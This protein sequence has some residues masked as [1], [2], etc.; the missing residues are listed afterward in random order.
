MY[1]PTAQTPQSDDVQI[2]HLGWTLHATNLVIPVTGRNSNPGMDGVHV[3][4]VSD[5]AG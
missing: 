2:P 3:Q 5:E 1:V 4:D